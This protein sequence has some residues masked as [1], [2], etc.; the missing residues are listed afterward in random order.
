MRRPRWRRRELRA[1]INREQRH[2][3]ELQAKAEVGWRTW[4]RANIVDETRF[5]EASQ[6]RIRATIEAVEA[7]VG[8]PVVRQSI[9]SLRKHMQPLLGGRT[10][11][12]SDGDDGEKATAHGHVWLYRRK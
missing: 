1:Q 12:V 2:A 8:L 4:I 11:P 10:R 3:D 6:E 7:K 9:E 5:E